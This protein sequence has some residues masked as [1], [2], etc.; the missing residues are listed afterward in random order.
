MLQVWDAN[1]RANE[2]K[3]NAMEVLIRS[4]Q[5]KERVEQNNEQLRHLIKEIRELLTSRCRHSA[6]SSGQVKSEIFLLLL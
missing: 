1:V 6:L 5:S 2:A 4:N 3:A